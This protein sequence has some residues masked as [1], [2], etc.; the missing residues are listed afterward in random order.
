MH[1]RTLSK[2]ACQFLSLSPYAKGAGQ[3]EARHL[4][5]LP[6]DQESRKQ[7]TLQPQ[8]KRSCL[9]DFGSANLLLTVKPG[10]MCL[11]KESGKQHHSREQDIRLFREPK[12]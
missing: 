11:E 8:E 4:G 7:K 2:L 9:E 12:R 3:S 1:H 10:M 6:H 5:F